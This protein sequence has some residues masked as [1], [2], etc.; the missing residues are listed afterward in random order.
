M[1]AFIAGH[2]QNNYQVERVKDLTERLGLNPSNIL[3]PFAINREE[4]F[5]IKSYLPT[6]EEKKLIMQADAF[7]LIQARF[8]FGLPR[9]TEAYTKNWRLT[10]YAR[11]RNKPLKFYRINHGGNCIGQGF[12]VQEK[13]IFTDEICG[14]IVHFWNLIC[15]N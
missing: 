9:A 7:Y 11:R 3:N 2:W 8:D 6:K 5:K 1:K 14:A 13:E 12:E 4:I 10:E 15:K